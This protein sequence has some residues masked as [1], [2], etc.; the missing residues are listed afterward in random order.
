MTMKEWPKFDS[1]GDL[2]VGIYQATLAEVIEHFGTG[3]LQRQIVARRLE[4]IYS[5]ASGTG[6]M[7]RF[8]VFGSFVTGKPE[9][10]DVDI[11]LLMEDT[12]DSGQIFG[13]A[14]IIFDHTAAQH[15]EGA[16]VFWIRQMAA[17]GGEQAA[18][19]YWQ[20]KRDK[21]QRGIIEVVS[22]D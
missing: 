9:P 13:E 14:S 10:N 6:Q 17:I 8:V 5:L 15:H 11:F 7:A 22:H 18:L 20:I 21:T 1:N 19:E 4:R 12:F 2:P 16:S 3:T